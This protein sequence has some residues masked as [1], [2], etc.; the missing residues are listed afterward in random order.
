M[1]VF[2]QQLENTGFKQLKAINP[3]S[4]WCY[5]AQEHSNKKHKRVR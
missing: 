4:D 1:G 5:V 3:I 2:S